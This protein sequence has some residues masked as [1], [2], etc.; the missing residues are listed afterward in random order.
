MLQSIVLACVLFSAA[1]ALGEQHLRL[2]TTTSTEN[3]GLLKVLLPPFEKR[4]GKAVDVIAVGSGKAMKL[5][6]NGDVDVVLS[7]A[8]ELEDAFVAAG[9]GVNRRDV[10]YNDFVIVGPRA[11]PAKLAGSKS[12]VDAFKQLA[13]AQAPFISRG[14]ESGTHEKEKELWKAAGGTPSGAWYVSAGVGMGQT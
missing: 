10:M 2:A 5:G 9:F 7:H 14:D 4:F 12:A 3:T 8:P 6:E 11:D 1:A 13:S